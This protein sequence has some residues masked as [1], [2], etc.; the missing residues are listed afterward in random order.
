[1]GPIEY[2]ALYKELKSFLQWKYWYK[3]VKKKIHV[4]LFLHQWKV[5]KGLKIFTYVQG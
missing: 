2:E 5:V 4:Y 3:I 1:M